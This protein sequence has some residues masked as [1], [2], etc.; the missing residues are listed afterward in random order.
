LASAD[1]GS[2][3]QAVL[4]DAFPIFDPTPI[5]AMAEQLFPGKGT[6]LSDL[7]R[8]RQ[9]EYAWLR[10]LGGRYQDFWQI[11]KSAL[12]FA[13]ESLKLDLTPE[14]RDRLMEGYLKLK[15]WPE[16]PAVLKS[17]REQ[18]LRLAFLSNFTPRMLRACIEQSGMEGI[19][20]HVLSTDAVRTYKP[21]PRAYQMGIDAFHLRREQMVFVAFAGWDVA[22]ANWFGYPTFWANRRNQRVAEMGVLPDA[23]GSDLSTLKNFVRP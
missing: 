4:F 8:N 11:T 6:E 5:F 17:L 9:F 3:V 2:R 19:F 21:D 23:S 15:T 13:A 14:K 7:W 1:S 22:G 10:S 18:G 16:V 12:V 20:E